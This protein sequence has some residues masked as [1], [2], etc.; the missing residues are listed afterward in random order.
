MMV[1]LADL[2]NN[3]AS[4]PFSRNGF[5]SVIAL[6]AIFLFINLSLQKKDGFAVVNAYPRDW[7]RRHAHD[8]FIADA[9]GL[10]LEGLG[11]ACFII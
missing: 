11:K 7:M 2:Y 4:D 1:Y 10:I 8:A 9:K 5:L 3:A 6:G